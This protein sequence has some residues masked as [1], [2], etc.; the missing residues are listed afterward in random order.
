MSNAVALRDLVAV[1]P[2]LHLR[3]SGVTATILSLVPLQAREIAIAA[4][5]VGLPGGIPRFPLIQLLTQGWSRPPGRPFRIWHARRNDEMLVGILLRDLLRQPWK[6]VF[7]SDAQRRHTGWTRFLLDRMD[8][9]ICTSPGGCACLD[10][11]AA[12]VPHGVDTARFRPAEDRAAE[13]AASGLPGRRGIGVFGRIR[14]SKG[15]DL[16]VEAMIR[17]LPRYPDVTAVVTGLATPKER[18]FLEALQRKV[19][20]AGLE[21]RI[22][23]L[24]ECPPEEMPLWFRRVSVL[25]APQRIEGFGLTPLEAMASGTAVVATRTGAAPVLILDGKTGRL[26]PPNDLEALVAAIDP[27]LADPDLAERMGRAGREHVCA[28]HDIAREVA[29]LAAVYEALWAG[30]QVSRV[31]SS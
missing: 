16:F 21:E 24:G 6:L 29:G 10:R 12:L 17:L 19:R 23:F 31:R 3:W 22:R 28:H 7:T 9:L 15:T 30:E 2:N 26:V 8:G 18:D 27:L 1:A 5:G 4:T 20:Q 25:V 14:A 11:P 13:W